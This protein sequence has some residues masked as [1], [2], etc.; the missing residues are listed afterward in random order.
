M[1][2]PALALLTGCIATLFI[3]ALILAIVCIAEA[4]WSS[5]NAD[6]P[7]RHRAFVA[8]R[9]RPQ[10]VVTKGINPISQ[11]DNGGTQ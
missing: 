8:S 10:A 3:C 5:A 11:E 7:R 9:S 6:A 4:I 2:S 1:I